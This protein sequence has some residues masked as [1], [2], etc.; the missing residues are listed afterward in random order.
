MTL[1]QY[2]ALRIW[3]CTHQHPL[4]RNAWDAVLTLWILGWAGFPAAWLLSLSWAEA[5]CLLMLFVP[6]AYVA[7]RRG[8]HRAGRLRCDWL[9]AR[10]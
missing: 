3:H 2:H 7:W 10:R 9:T 6:S 8:L 4:E 1:G 5:G